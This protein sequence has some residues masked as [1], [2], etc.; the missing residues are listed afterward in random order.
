M[1]MEKVKVLEQALALVEASAVELVVHHHHKPVHIY[2]HHK[3]Q[4]DLRR[5]AQ[6]HMESLD[7]CTF[8]WMVGLAE[9][10]ELVELVPVPVPVLVHS[11]NHDNPTRPYH[12]DTL[13]SMSDPQPNIVHK[14]CPSKFHTCLCM[15]HTHRCK[16]LLCHHKLQHQQPMA[17]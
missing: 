7:T 9:S 4:Q 16:H 13:C 2:L 6:K 1:V 8:H 11:S 10:V 12:S 14:N 17:T 3:N 5:T 15:V